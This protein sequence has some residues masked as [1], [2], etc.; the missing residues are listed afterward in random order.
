[1]SGWTRTSSRRIGLVTPF[2]FLSFLYFFIVIRPDQWQLASQ[3]PL[4][5]EGIP[6]KIWYKLGPRGLTP[7]AEIWTDSCISQ[8]PEYEYEFMTDEL[9]EIWVAE[10]FANHPEIVETYH[11]LTIPILKADIL[12]YL[13]LFVEGGVYAD[14]DITCN[15]PIDEWIPAEYQA[16]SSLVVGWEFDVGW[17]ENIV[18]E[19]AT[20]TIMAKRHSPHMW[21]LIED[22]IQLIGEK[23]KAH[24]FESVAQLTPALAGDVVDTTGP[25]MFTKSIIKSLEQVLEAPVDRDSIKNLRQPK[26]VGDVLILPGFSFA[27]GSNHYGPEEQLGPPLVT[28]HGA[29]SWKNEHGGE[30]VL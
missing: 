2:I 7:E 14:L 29:G 17:G 30:L 1:M 22:I 5:P 24:S 19:F 12:R 8:N 20:W 6:K 15:V 26:L 11:N 27:A 18:R 13:L 25:R 28:H 16:N 9:S 21:T 23:T 4:G 3:T 10:Q